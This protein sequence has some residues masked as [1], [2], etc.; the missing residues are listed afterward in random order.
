MIV[1]VI[2]WIGSSF[3][4]PSPE[5]S[6]F[7]LAPPQ[8]EPPSLQGSLL[9]FGLYSV[10][11]SKQG[12]F[13][14]LSLDLPQESDLPLLVLGFLSH[15]KD[16]SLALAFLQGLSLGFI[17]ESSFLH[18]GETQPGFGLSEGLQGSSFLQLL[19][20]CLTLSGDFI[21]L[22]HS[23]GLQGSSFLQPLLACILGFA[24][25]EQGLEILVAS[26]HLHRANLKVSVILSMNYYYEDLN[27]SEQLVELNR[28]ELSFIISR[29][30]S[31]SM[32]IEVFCSGIGCISL[33]RTFF[34][35][36]C[37]FIHGTYV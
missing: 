7:F 1:S 34:K 24:G 36:L 35:Q 31:V 37:I 23:G 28:S 9:H 15:F 2:V 27:L 17:Q 13:C 33:N 16:P 32:A 25:G 22:G 14:F 12:F 3:L 4:P 6:A 20:I 21:G 29:S 8:G 10:W 19:V 18:L 5:E 26:V 30:S 11:S